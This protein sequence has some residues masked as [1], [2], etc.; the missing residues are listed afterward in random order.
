MHAFDFILVLFSFVYAAAVTQI[1]SS[2]GEIVIEAKRITLSLI[3]AG[4][5][6]VSLLAICSWWISFWD[7]R[8]IKVWTVANIG[9][10]FGAAAAFYILA[11][12]VSP[13]IPTAG[14]LDL[15][16]FHTE[17]G[18]K[19]LALY[20][21]LMALS[22]AAN[23]YYGQA[24]AA[25]ELLSQNAACI[26]MLLAAATAAVFVRNRTVQVGALVVELAAWVWYYGALQNPLAG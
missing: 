4:W 20:A 11:R 19:Y 5:M 3:N 9:F 6:L 24:S 2:A 26:P 16:R 21:V 10:E 13:R 12:M 1:L 14:E 15:Q 7:M 25:V 22:I 18:R 8:T 17:E 23:I